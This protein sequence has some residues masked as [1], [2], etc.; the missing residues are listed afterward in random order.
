MFR[1]V[2]KEQLVVPARI[3]H[4]GDLRDFVTRFGKKQGISDRIIN[5]FKLSVDEAA[6]NIIK[7]AYRDWDGDITIR[8]ILKKDTINIVLID[9]GKFFDPRQV[10]DPDLQRYVNIGK[11]GG[12]GIFIMRRLLDNIEYRKSEDGNELWLIKYQESAQKRKMTLPSFSISLKAKYWLLAMFIYSLVILGGYVF[13]FLQ[14]KHVVINTYLGQAKQA[15]A[16]LVREIENNMESLPANKKEELLRQGNYDIE[17]IRHTGRP[18]HALSRKNEDINMI[19]AF[20][21]TNTGEVIASSDTAY[22][23]IMIDSFF[24]PDKAKTIEEN[25]YSYALQNGR[26]VLDVVQPVLDEQNRPLCFAH[27]QIN[28]DK[29]Q[30][31]ILDTR[32]D[33]AKLAFFI[34]IAGGASIFLLVY[35]VINPFQRLADWVKQIGQPGVVEEMD[36]DESTEVGEIA[37]AFSDITLRLRASQENLAEQERLQKE[38]QVAQEIQQTLLP[39]EF[40]AVEGYE[41]DSYYEAAKE[42]GGDYFDFVEVDKETLGIVVGDVSGKGVPGSLVMTMIRTA[43]RTEARGVKDAAEVLARVNDFVVN[44]MKK[45]MFVTLFYVIID[46]RR[47]KLNY[48]SAGHNPMILYRTSTQKTYYLNPRGFPIGI[49][50]PDK[51]L[52]RKSIE[53]DT[54]SLTE[55]DILIVYTDGITEAMNQ[56]RHLFGEERFLDVVRENGQFTA[57]VFVENLQQSL[58]QFTEGTPQN[59]DITLVAI[60]EKTTADKLEH[61]HAKQVYQLIEEGVSIKEACDQV[62]LSSYAYYNKYKDAFETGNFEDIDFDLEADQIESR[63]LSIEEKTK[64]YDIIRRFPQYGAKRIQE[65]LKSEAYGR[66]NISVAKIY[67]ELVRAR[68]NTKEL[69][70]A[71]VHRAG[72]K[73]KRLKPPGTPMLTLDGRV[74]IKKGGFQEEEFE[75]EETSEKPEKAQEETVARDEEKPQKPKSPKE[76]KHDLLHT[77]P[78][79]LFNMSLEDLLDKRAIEVEGKK[80]SDSKREPEELEAPK[81][82]AVESIEELDIVPPTSPDKKKIDE[83]EIDFVRL[84]S[85]GEGIEE[86]QLEEQEN[87]PFDERHTEDAEIISESEPDNG[88]IFDPQ[89]DDAFNEYM[90]IEE[91]HGLI[92][93]EGELAKDIAQKLLRRDAESDA[94]ETEDS[95]ISSG[96]EKMD[97]NRLITVL[98]N[99]SATP[100][101]QKTVKRFSETKPKSGENGLDG[102]QIEL[103]RR[104]KRALTLYKGQKFAEMVT[105]AEKLYRDYPKNVKVHLLL[106]SAYLKNHQYEQAKNI[107]QR[108]IK[109]YPMHTIAYEKLGTIYADQGE[110]IKAIECWEKVIAKNPKRREIRTSLE[111]AREIVLR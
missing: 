18:I 39:S 28:Y 48:A 43:L 95:R 77:T 93:P 94:P 34:W 63:H 102:N 106:G 45:G 41:I 40:P 44:D 62:G 92:T 32:W 73:K 59:D 38:M 91:E 21:R 76:K 27:Y 6:T 23:R 74:I 11:K 19:H 26:T 79:Q 108:I 88:S 36:I 72:K 89:L 67:S 20:V 109:A 8:A 83:E 10:N 70:E 53:S 65:E 81:S 33:Y 46:S 42:V 17:V 104:I 35:L 55:D 96:G 57:G 24:I 1:R 52:F 31:Q 85:V 7:H 86:P 15:C 107:Y 37:K 64:I 87:H 5:A 110:F 90:E 78:P 60:K 56:K 66:S 111:R 99:E 100:H 82:A 50:L 22:L 98:T 14:Q 84:I 101:K 2:V 13:F 69:R 47:R 54:I 4:L 12:L 103:K 61:K 25:I 68:L 49:S 105:E 97:F 9:Q 16:S 51:D 30:R 58:R 71:Y 3:E 29:I 80:S 75:E